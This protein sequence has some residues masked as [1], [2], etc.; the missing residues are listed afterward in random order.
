MGPAL[1]LEAA[2]L[3]N[4]PRAL[5]L[6]GTFPNMGPPHRLYGTMLPIYGTMLPKVGTVLFFMGSLLPSEGMF[7]RSEGTFPF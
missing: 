2:F 4:M 1:R 6:Y 7:L 5:R 3:K